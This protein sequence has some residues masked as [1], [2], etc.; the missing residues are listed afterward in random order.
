MKL[1]LKTLLKTDRRYILRAALI[2][3][4]LLLAGAGWGGPTVNGLFYGDGD[5]NSYVLYNTSVGGSKLWYTVVSNRLYVA[6]VVDRSVNDNVFGNR[7]YTQ[8]AGWNPPHTANRLVDSEYAQFTLTVGSTTYQWNQGYG[9]LVGGVWKSDH[10]TGAGSGTPPAGYISSSSFAWN[11]NNYLNN[12]APAWNM[13]V[14]GSDSGNWKSPFAAGAP[15][16]VLGLDGYPATGAITYSHLYQWEWPMVYEWSVDL[17]TF[18][19]SPI[20]VISGSSHHSPAKSGGENDP[21]SDPP[22]NGYLS[23][24][25]DLPA[26]YPTR[27]TDNGPCH[28]IVPNGV[29]L[30]AMGP[31]PEPDGVPDA[32]A[33]GDDRLGAGD[34]DGVAVVSMQAGSSLTLKITV[35]APGYLSAFLD[36]SGSG[37]LTAANLLAA[38]G[39]AALAPGVMTDLYIPQGGVYTLTIAVP[40]G[41]AEKIAARFRITNAA[42]QGG[43]A[44]TGV[45]QSGEVEDYLWERNSVLSTRIDLTV[46]GAGN[47]KV[48]IEIATV[49]ENGRNDIEIYAMLNG[50]WALVANVPS[51]QIVGI[52]SNLYTAEAFGLTPG[53]SYLFRIVDESGHIFESEPITVALSQVLVEAVTLTPELIK[54]AFNTEYGLFYQVMVCEQ[55]G[56][57]WVVEYARYPTARGLSALSNEPFMAGPGERTEVLIPRNNRP[58]AFFRITK[59]Q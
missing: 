39:A 37:V 27:L 9:A 23:D 30:G 20:F 19:P 13:Y 45:A 18:G 40:S 10:T 44:P 43:A 31:D 22:G 49:N 6:L 35:S 42:G 17:S 14:D 11:I 28:Y 56:A 47:G 21:F 25:G 3:S 58:Q 34:E 24:Y 7:T 54:V 38:T 50:E 55:L 12:A 46:H 15:N 16:V 48:M 2:S 51:A 26:P 57:P 36:F 32:A 1:S 4:V 5:Q 41:I 59:V 29:Y 33:A 53:K 8:N 52:G